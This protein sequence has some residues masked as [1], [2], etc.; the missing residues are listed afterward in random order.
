M[1]QI[2]KL[3]AL[4]AGA[5]TIGLLMGVSTAQAV[6]FDLDGS[7]NVIRINN[8]EL[9]LDDDALDGL[10]NVEF[11]NDTG[12][13]VY[14]SVDGPF[15]FPLAEDAVTVAIQLNN[16]LNLNNPVP[17]GASSAGSNQFFIPGIEYFGFWAG[18]G[19]E[20]QLQS[21]LWDG[22]LAVLNPEEINTFAK[23]SV[24]AVP[25]PTAVWLFGSGLLGLVGVARR[26][27]T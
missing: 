25:V 27:S 1:R 7:N 8:L 18:F 17:T 5:V 22:S 26:K 15:D 4:A 10:Y 16:A 23:F 11:I 20:Y 13:N 9:N 2:K 14:G 12:L 24:S 21:G 3:S 6:T 19:S